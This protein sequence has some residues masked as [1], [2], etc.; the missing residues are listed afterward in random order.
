MSHFS[1]SW[2]DCPSGL[3]EG[4]FR[5]EDCEGIHSFITAILERRKAVLYAK[6]MGEKWTAGVSEPLEAFTISRP[7]SSDRFFLG[8]SMLSISDSKGYI[9]KYN[10][11]ISTTSTPYEYKY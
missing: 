5:D 9:S 3:F 10:C 11:R 7:R 2:A 8:L 1:F 6:V 4:T